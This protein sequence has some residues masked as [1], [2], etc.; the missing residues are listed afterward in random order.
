MSDNFSP[1][2]RAFGRQSATFDAIDAES[3]IIG[4]MRQ[5]VYRHTGSFLQPHSQ[6]LE[7]NA[8]TGID[9]C[10][11]AS[12]GHYV[13][14]TDL[15]AD[16]LRQADIKIESL[17]LGDKVSTLQCNYTQLN[18]LGYHKRF[19]HI[20]SN[21]G[22]LNCIPDF[23]EVGRHFDKL[24]RPGGYVSL[25]M[26]SPFC[27]WEFLLAFKGNFKLAFRRFSPDGAPSQLEGEIFNTYYFSP[28]HIQQSLG[29][30][31]VLKKV[32]GLAVA[33]PPPYL[34]ARFSKSVLANLQSIDKVISEWPLFRKIGDHYIITLQYLP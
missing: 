21:F 14:A 27:L 28:A 24:L 5:R 26:I 8:G 13:I 23:S 22:G 30:D 29:P 10:H 20:F 2:A 12:L 19:D 9:A 7:L 6:I 16:M 17:Q 25:V 34:E 11:F 1:V 33:V 4:W 15:S 32:E 3:S 31:F 18:R